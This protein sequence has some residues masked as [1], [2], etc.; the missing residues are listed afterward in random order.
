MRVAV[1]GSGFVAGLH[2]DALNGLA[3]AEV[4]GIVD[5]DRKRAAET[6]RHAGG[7]EWHTSLLDAVDAWDVDAA[8]VCTPNDTHLAIGRQLVDARVHA[9][10][11]KPLAVTPRDA[12]EL[13]AAFDVNG[14]VLS[15]AHTHRFG[16]Y[17][18]TIKQAI[19]EGDIGRP[20]HARLSTLNGWIWA[21]WR[22][23]QLNRTRSG[24]H[25]F[26]NG[27]HLLDLVTWWLDDEPAHVHALGRKQSAAQLEIHDYML[28]T[29]GYT[30]GATAVCEISRA[31]HPRWLRYRDIFVQGTRGSL[32]MPWDGD[33]PLLFADQGTTPVS[34]APDPFREQARAWIAA[35]RGVSSPTVTGH[36]GYRAVL[37]AEAA[38][39][40]L[41]SGD[42][43]AVADIDKEPAHA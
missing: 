40:S 16:A 33:G 25:A 7:M 21:D 41:S 35:V 26:H 36:D 10:I 24:G 17:S 27:V 43:V 37:L 42:V 13:K 15:A 32:R 12:A 1:I 39:R 9:L 28:I 14:L 29:V 18:R 38:E 23:W 5:L 34:T 3:D 31:N 6:A 11:E 8:I 4:V 22:G 2:L 30:S 20:I 19:T